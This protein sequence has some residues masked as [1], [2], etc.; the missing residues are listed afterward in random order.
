MY[1]T[2]IAILSVLPYPPYSPVL[3]IYDHNTGRINLLILRLESYLKVVK[4]LRHGAG[5]G[6]QKAMAQMG[7]R[8]RMGVNTPVLVQSPRPPYP[9]RFIVYCDILQTVSDI[10]L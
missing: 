10:F 2:F 3:P 1:I 5:V 9:L 8:D 6:V 7:W 4:N